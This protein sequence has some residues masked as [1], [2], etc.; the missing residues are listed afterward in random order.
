MDCHT[1]ALNKVCDFAEGYVLVGFCL[2]CGHFADLKDLPPDL[3]IPEIRLH[4][5]CK[6][7][8]SRECSLRIVYTGVG[9]FRYG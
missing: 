2:A 3:P 5:V 7:C 8:R 4:L 6:E 1:R 9:E